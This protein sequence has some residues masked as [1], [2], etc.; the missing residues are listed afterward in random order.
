MHNCNTIVFVN[1]PPV[2]PLKK[3]SNTTTI[4]IQIIK[5]Y[6]IKV[7]LMLLLVGA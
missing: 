4:E 5:K 3:D 1:S 2:P 7:Q 6:I